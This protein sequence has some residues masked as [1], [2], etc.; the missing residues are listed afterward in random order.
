MAFTIRHKVKATFQDRPDA[1][2]TRNQWNDEHVAEG[3]ELGDVL[4]PASAVVGN[5]AV[6]ADS[7]GKLLIDGGGVVTGSAVSSLASSVYSETIARSNADS[8]LGLAITGVTSASLSAVASEAVIR[9]TADSSLTLGVSSASSKATSVAAD[10]ASF[11]LD[12]NRYGFLNQTET[13]IAFDG[14]NTFTLGSVGATWSYYRTSVKYT[15]SGSKTVDLAVSPPAATGMYYVY[16]DSTTGTLVASTVAWTLNDTKVPVAAVYWNNSNTPKY[17][18]SEERHTCLI[19][20]RSHYY[21]HFLEGTRMRTVGG[22]TGPTVSSTADVD[23]TCAVAVSTLVDEDIIIPIAA[24]TAPNGTATDYVGFYR[25]SST[26]WS[27]KATNMPFLYNVVGANNI[28]Q[29][30]DAGTMTDGTIGLGAGRRWQNS[31]LC[32]SNMDPASTGASK[33]RIF[34]IS[35]RAQ[36]S[37]LALAQAEDPSTFTFSNFPCAEFY[38]AYRLT[39]LPTTGAGS[40]NCVLASTPLAVRVAAIQTSGTATGLEHNSLAGLQGGSPST[41]DYFHVPHGVT[42]GDVTRFNSVT[43]LWEVSAEPLSFKGLILT[44]AASALSVAE[45]AIYYNSSSKDIQVCTSAV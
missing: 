11:E 25:T 28:I 15:I 14:A 42:T 6:F 16:I 22:L 33:A 34:V 27:W 13:T 4:G 17:F 31:Y 23:K 38:I 3:G 8:S 37:T 43:G 26:A 30:D 18:L 9:S 24:L 41:G 35:G 12:V 5:V 32:F 40:G 29:W 20:R 21:E 7:S 2:V 19:D 44:P 10:L 1:T 45:G 39:W 36:F